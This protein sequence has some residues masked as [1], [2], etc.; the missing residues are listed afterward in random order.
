MRF[1]VLSLVSVASLALASCSKP[2]QAAAPTC[3]QVTDHVLAMVQKQYPGHGDMGGMGNRSAEVEQCKARQVTAKERRCILAA[4]DM[5]SI[6]R[7]RK[8]SQT[9]APKPVP[10]V[11]PVP[12]PATP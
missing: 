5:E 10:T 11:P 12:V 6:G 7:C 1:L 8:G 2:E 4:T 3:E 9:A